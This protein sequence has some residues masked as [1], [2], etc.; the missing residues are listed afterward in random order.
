[1]KILLL[2]CSGRKSKDPNPLPAKDR[3]Q[4]V[5]VRTGLTLA[6]Q[7]GYDVHILSAKFGFVRPDT[8]I[9][10]YDQR[11]A[12]P[13]TGEWPKG[14][15]FYLGGKDYFGKCPTRFKPLVEGAG[16]G[17][18]AKAAQKLIKDPGLRCGRGIVAE[19]YKALRTGKRTKQE[20]EQILLTEFPYGHRKMLNTVRIQLNQSRIGDER[21]CILMREGS[22]QNRRYWLVPKADREFIPKAKPTVRYT[23]SLFNPKRS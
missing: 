1:M 23:C 4:G 17:I 14:K 2:A 8:P 9:P 5:L 19:M 10:Y 20:L 12:A 18:L 3:Y 13:Y 16:I 15:G 22:L 6:E 21:G 7:E 11:M